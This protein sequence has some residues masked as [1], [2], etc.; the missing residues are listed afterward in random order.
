M[1]QEVKHIINQ[2][3]I[4][5]TKLPEVMSMIERAAQIMEEMRIDTDEDEEKE[6]F[7]LQ[8]NLRELTGK[9]NFN[10]EEVNEYWSYTNLETVAELAL[11]QKPQRLGLSEEVLRELLEELFASDELEKEATLDY[12]TDFFEIE[13]Q[14][15]EVMDYFYNIDEQGEIGYASIDEIMERIALGKMERQ[16]QK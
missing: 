12:W 2:S 6:L 5:E 16:W 15:E 3:K 13:T 1:R 4:D 10:I 11:M 9:E 14:I 7:A 8:K